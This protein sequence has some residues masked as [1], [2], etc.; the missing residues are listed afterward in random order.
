VK[1]KKKRKNLL[2]SG[3]LILNHAF[4]RRA[5]NGVMVSSSGSG[6]LKLGVVMDGDLVIILDNSE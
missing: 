6:F 1:F 2:N 3:I 5:K 4:M